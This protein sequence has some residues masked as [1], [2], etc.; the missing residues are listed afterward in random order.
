M[1]KGLENIFQTWIIHSI[2]IL[3]LIGSPKELLK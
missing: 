1:V 2:V 3:I